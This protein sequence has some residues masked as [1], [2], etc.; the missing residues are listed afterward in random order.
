MKNIILLISV[1]LIGFGCS[2]KDCVKVSDIVYSDLNESEESVYT[3]EMDTFSFKFP[4][5]VTPNNDGVNDTILMQTNITEDVVVSSKFRMTNNCNKVVFS[6][7]AN[8]PF[9]FPNPKTWE[10]GQYDFT[11]HIMLP[12]NK[13][14]S[15]GGVFRVI[16]K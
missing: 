11:F 3:F 7:E 5:Y 16:S 9:V 4:Q 14:L 1:I 15:G 6:D 8:F 12:N 2:D 10:D 13:L